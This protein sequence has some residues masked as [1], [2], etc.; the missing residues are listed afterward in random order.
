VVFELQLKGY[1]PILAHP[2][3]YPFL[4]DD[5]RELRRIQEAGC[6]LQI[7]LL[8]LTGHYGAGP[9]ASAESMI[10]KGLISFL[11]TDAHHLTH[12]KELA[13]IPKSGSTLR[14]LEKGEFDNAKLTNA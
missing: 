4:C 7:N 9:R 1:R 8:S 6:R 13:R 5:W 3:R 2:E 12:L 11:G 14:L 10:K